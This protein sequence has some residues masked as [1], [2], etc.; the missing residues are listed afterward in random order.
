M[1]RSSGQRVFAGLLVAAIVFAASPARAIDKDQTYAQMISIARQMESLKPQIGSDPAAAATYQSLASQYRQLSASMGGDDPGT[2][3]NDHP[4]DGRVPGG[5]PIPATPPN[6]AAT[7]T[8][9][10]QNTPVAIPTGPAVVTSTINVAGAGPYL[11]DINPQTFITHTFAAD[12]DITIQSPAG[13]VV[14]LTTD[15]GGGNDDVF[16]GTLWD[17]SANPGGQVPYTTND[18]VITDS[19]F[20]NLVVETPLVPEEALSAFIGE[21]PNGT[22]TLTVS[23]DLAGDGGSIASWNVQLTTL[24]AAPTNNPAAVFSQPAPVAIP[25]GPAVVTSTIAVAGVTNPICGMTVT[26]NITHTFAADL[27]VT[28][29]SPAGTIA[30]LTT[31]NGGGNDNVF[32]GT[33]WNDDADPGN[34][35]P[36]V[37]DPFFVTEHTYADLTLASPLIA[38][39]ALGPFI[40]QSANGNWTIT[41][42]DDLAGDGGSITW[43]VSFTP[44]ACLA[45]CQLTCPANVTVGNDANQCGAVVNYPAPTTTG[46]CGTIT[47]V[48]PSGSFFPVAPTNITC[49]TVGGPSCGFTV[50]VNDTQ[51]PAI[52]CPAD[53]GAIVPPGSAGGPVTFPPPTVSDNCPGAGSVCVPASGDFF[54]VGTTVDTCTATDAANNAASCD[55]NVDVV[56]QVIQEIPALSGAGL[57]GLAALLALAGFLAIRRRN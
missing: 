3:I 4:V 45:A 36:Y 35:V 39:E 48:P 15:N 25:T 8:T 53:V 38:E 10:T 11:W 14:T 32:N 17:D 24:A 26:T 16:N 51:P 2:Q 49:S 29:M 56:A 47:C 41:V 6:C 27:D 5:N 34:Q 30:T 23:D 21:N 52:T 40:G 28:L 57:A 13:T 19:T 43:S 37:A 46:A 42:S 31:D 7:T 54:P 20:A 9:F 22:W 55:F 12:L 1:T 33:V 18:G 44:C 50:T